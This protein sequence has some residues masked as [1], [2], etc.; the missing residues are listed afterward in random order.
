MIGIDEW[1]G[2]AGAGGGHIIPRRW[3]W[4]SCVVHRCR[5]VDACPGPL[6]VAC[7][8]CVFIPRC[9]GVVIVR[10]RP[11]VVP[12]DGRVFF[13]IVVESTLCRLVVVGSYSSHVVVVSSSRGLFVASLSSCGVVLG[14]SKVGSEEGGMGY[15][16]CLRVKYTSSTI[17][18][19]VEGMVGTRRL[20]G[21][22][23][24]VARRCP[25]ALVPVVVR[26]VVGVR[27]R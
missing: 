27:Y 6:L 7:P 17:V 26:G 9:G 8:G 22:W 11:L 12:C 21:W 1:G 2:S 5:L 10:R 13:C 3:G 14:L 25:W 4:A 23:T 24:S 15:L 19:V 20:C 16:L 18:R